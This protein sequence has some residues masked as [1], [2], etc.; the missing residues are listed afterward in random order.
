MHSSNAVVGRSRFPIAKPTITIRFRSVCLVKITDTVSADRLG[1]EGC[2]YFPE[3]RWR[4]RPMSEGWPPGLCG[5]TRVQTEA[6]WHR[7]NG[8]FP[9]GYGTG[10]GIA[11]ICHF[12]DLHRAGDLYREAAAPACWTAGR[13]VR[14]LRCRLI[15]SLHG[16]ARKHLEPW[17]RDRRPL[18]PPGCRGANG[19]I[20][21]VPACASAALDEASL[22]GLS[23]RRLQARGAGQGP[24]DLPR[25][26]EFLDYTHRRSA[27]P[28]PSKSSAGVVLAGGTAGP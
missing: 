27:A 28:A 4:H 9:G 20:R 24:D 7:L 18:P 5:R 8:P 19:G 23:S 14:V 22:P 10:A 6:I 3:A 21:Q 11:S 25:G 2:A 17:P 26:Q 12:G 13:P 16:I 15:A 1:R